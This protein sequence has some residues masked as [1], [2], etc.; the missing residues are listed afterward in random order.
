MTA[1]MPSSG[2]DWDSHPPYI[3]PDYKSTPLRGPSKPLV[4]LA[5][6]LS[7]LTGPV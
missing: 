2:R 1:E 7:E 5:A 6:S 3:Y 4:P